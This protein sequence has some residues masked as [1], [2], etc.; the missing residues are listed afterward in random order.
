MKTDREFD[1]LLRDALG[2]AGRPA[3]FTVDV[4]DRVM[5]RIAALGPPPRAELAIRQLVPWAAA[6]AVA[7]AALVIVA[8]GKGPTLV[9]AVSGLGQ[10]LAGT[11]GLAAKLTASGGALAASA[12]RVGLA[13]A[14]AVEALLRPVAPFQP[15]A[16]ALL[17]AV[18][19][20][21]A[22]ISAFIIARDV[23]ARVTLEEHS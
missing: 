9:D 18:A 4:E 3:P 19:V 7:G 23:R 20:G 5:A 21:M 17:E 13:L 14:T 1:N 16:H 22:G 8:I 2:R 6:A 15:L 12:G 10:T 11:S